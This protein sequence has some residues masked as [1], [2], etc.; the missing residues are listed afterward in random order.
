M[1]V[2]PATVECDGKE[3][4]MHLATIGFTKL[5][6]EDHGI[7]TWVIDLD[8]GSSGQS[9]GAYAL[10]DPALFGNHIQQL[11]NFFGTGWENL[12]GKR[13]YALK[14]GYN[15][16]VRGF[17]DEKQTKMVLFSDWNEIK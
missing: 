4:E 3:Y 10:N 11:C 13:V 9:A 1:R 5:G 6:K 7:F 2:K 16:P 8:F 15:G 14:E 17:M 12:K